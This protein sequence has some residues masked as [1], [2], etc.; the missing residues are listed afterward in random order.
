MKIL[1][2]APDQIEQE[3]RQKEAQDR[4]SQIGSGDRSERSALTTSPKAGSQTTGLGSPLPFGRDPTEIQ[5]DHRCFDHNE[6]P[7]S[8]RI[9]NKCHH[10]D[11]DPFHSVPE[12]TRHPVCKADSELLLGKAFGQIQFTQ[13]D[14]PRGGTAVARSPVLRAKKRL[15]VAY[16]LEKKEFFGLDFFVN[17]K[18]LIPR[19]ETELLVKRVLEL[20]PGARR[21]VE[22]GVGSGAIAVSLAKEL[23]Q[24]EIWATDISEGALAVARKNCEIHGVSERVHLFAWDLFSPLQ[25][26][27]GTFEVVVSNPPYIPQKELEGLA[28]EL[29]HEPKLALAG[30]EDGL[31]VITPLVQAAYSFL[32]PGG[33]L[34]LE[35]G[36]G[37]GQAVAEIA[38]KSG[39]E[40]MKC[41]PD[42]AG[43][44]RFFFAWRPRE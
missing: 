24:L 28:P 1:R 41:E 3:Q 7:R 14:G 40:N 38:K 39:F 6:Q 43:L 34:A 21:A 12:K 30:G 2:K 22:V 44:E 18:V 33:L 32:V 31:R 17:E 13:L 42:Y 11:P 9:S 36:T 4:R 29:H 15:P 16:L 37:Q 5:R 35:I 23:P 20:A 26:M 10:G 19:P 8:W 25:E 27:A